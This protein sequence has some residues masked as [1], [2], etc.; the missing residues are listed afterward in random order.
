MGF[1]TPIFVP[2]AKGLDLSKSSTLDEK[3]MT[4]A[5][6]VDYSIAGEARGRPGRG[7]SVQSTGVVAGVVGAAMNTAGLGSGIDGVSG[8]VDLSAAAGKSFGLSINGGGSAAWTITSVSGE[9]I[10]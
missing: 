7:A 9:M 5:V 10:S 2:L 6:N 8:S 3:D 1:T 4:K